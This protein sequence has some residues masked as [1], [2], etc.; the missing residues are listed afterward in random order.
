MS[1]QNQLRWGGLAAIAVASLMVL[2]AGLRGFGV[3]PLAGQWA[4]FVYV[5]LLFFAFTALYAA[6]ASRIGRIGFA[7]YVLAILGLGL[8]EVIAFLILAGFAGLAAAHDVQMFAWSQVPILHLAVLANTLGGILF[9][10]ATIRAGIFPRWTGALLIA[11][12]VAN[13]LNEYLIPV[14]A[15]MIVPAVLMAA[16]FAGM[17][18]ILWAGMPR[19]A[20]QPRLAS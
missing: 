14:P 12:E 5:I 9:G 17:G 16:A 2:A 1:V 7:G 19:P 8:T 6:Q 15:L 18:W 3:A 4:I 11:G 10:A 13:L 20:A